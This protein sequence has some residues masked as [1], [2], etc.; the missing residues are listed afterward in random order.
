MSPTTP[1]DSW[2]Q[3][4]KAA[5]AAL[6]E[7]LADFVEA[8]REK[9]HPESYLIGVLHKVQQSLGYLPREQLEAVAQLLQVP[10]STVT[11]VAT[12]YHFF[13]LTPQGKHQINICMGTA[14]YVR[15]AQAVA[16]KFMDELGVSFGET[17]GDGLFTLQGSRCLGT[18]GL[19]PVV[20]I[21]EDVH[22]Q[23]TPENVPVLLE[24]YRKNE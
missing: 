10:T 7:E 4:Q 16:D 12:F 17:S 13:R 18:C 21:D 23:V 24:Q 22:G 15:G 2:P 8:C 11:G 14:C 1:T 6:G 19:A 9:P 3:V 5:R 20:M